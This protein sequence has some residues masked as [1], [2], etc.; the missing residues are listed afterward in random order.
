LASSGRRDESAPNEMEVGDP[1]AL[2]DGGETGPV[3]A[4]SEATACGALSGAAAIDGTGGGP[5]VMETGMAGTCTIGCD[6]RAGVA[7]T[8]VR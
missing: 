7:G 4:G 8:D 6:E 3:D 2:V 1:I 5:E